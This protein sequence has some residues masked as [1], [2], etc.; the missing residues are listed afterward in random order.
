MPV[1][2]PGTTIKETKETPKMTFEQLCDCM[3]TFFNTRDYESKQAFKK[4][5]SCAVGEDYTNVDLLCNLNDMVY[6]Y[7]NNNENITKSE[8]RNLNTLCT[9]IKNITKSMEQY[10][11]TTQ[12]D[13]VLIS[14]LMGY[15]LKIT[16]NYFHDRH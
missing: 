9:G 1:T 4:G 3:N 15:I 12:M 8:K 10:N 13:K 11:I 6:N 2:K 5:F 16:R 14:T 7:C